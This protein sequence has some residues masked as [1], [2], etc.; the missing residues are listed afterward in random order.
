MKNIGYSIRTAMKNLKIFLFFTV[1]I[2]FLINVQGQDFTH[3]IMSELR[4]DESGNINCKLIEP[5]QS[6]IDYNMLKDDILQ[7]GYNSAEFLSK[8]SVGGAE[9]TVEYWFFTPQAQTAFQYAVDIWA[10]LLSSEVPIKVLAGYIPLPPGILG[11]AGSNYI[12]GNT[13]GTQRN[14]WYATALADKLAGENILIDP[15]D[16]Y[17]IIAV[18]NSN[19][20]NWYFGTDGNTP[21]GDFDFATV[22]LHELCHGLGFFGLMNYDDET[23]YGFY[24]TSTTTFPAI[25]DHYTYTRMGRNLLNENFFPNPSVE[26]G[27]A[28]TGDQI[29]FSG[30]NVIVAT[31]GKRALLFTLPI[32]LPGSSYVHLDEW[33]YPP[34]NE[35]S[36]MTPGLMPGESI[37]HPGPITLAIFDDI[38]WNGKVKKPYNENASPNSVA[39]GGVKDDIKIFPNPVTNHFSVEFKNASKGIISVTLFSDF[40]KGYSLGQW[41]LK[42]KSH[43]VDISGLGLGSGLYFLCLESVD[44]VPVVFPIYK[45]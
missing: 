40:G 22:V 25:Y 10:G 24:G 1:F 43:Y 9:I 31:K 4:I 12:V 44:K 14:T 41:S 33:E 11:S 38:G 13:P 2:L 21:S 30:N 19:Y 7:Q 42:E 39:G 23:G 20:P 36:L 26:L 45:E 15:D 16:D 3:G 6:T 28:L 29:L 17:D 18:F 5:E 27:D 35:N 8:N 37:L 32:W 34:G